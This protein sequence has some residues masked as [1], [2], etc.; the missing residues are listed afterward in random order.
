MGQ[1]N[2]CKQSGDDKAEGHALSPPKLD[3]PEVRNSLT[4]RDTPRYFVSTTTTLPSLLGVATSFPV[5]RGRNRKDS[6]TWLPLQFLPVYLCLPS[7]LL[8][9]FHKI[10]L[11]TMP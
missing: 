8:G 11:F 5:P 4:G 9:Q 6:G 10:A 2:C 7:R 1:A 3:Q